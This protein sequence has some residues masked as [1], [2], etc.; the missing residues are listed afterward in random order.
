MSLHTSG[1]DVPDDL[2]VVGLVI[3]GKDGSASSAGPDNDTGLLPNRRLA[4]SAV[5]CGDLGMRI[6]PGSRLDSRLRFRGFDIGAIFE[7]ILWTDVLLPFRR[8]AFV[9]IKGVAIPESKSS[10]SL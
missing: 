6:S 10:S 2:D 3:F 9:R 5:S 1:A 8:T 4:S 7:A